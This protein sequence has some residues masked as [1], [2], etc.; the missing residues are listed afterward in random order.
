MKNIRIEYK[1]GRPALMV[2]EKQLPPVIYGLS[3]FPAAKSNT[4]Q[5]QRNIANFAAQGVRMVTADTNLSY[6]WHKFTPFDVEPIQAE[7]AG[8]LDAD[9]D[10]MVLLRLHMNPPYWWLRDHPEETAWYNGAP[11]IDDGEPVRMIRD[12]GTGFGGARGRLRVCLG[13]KLWIKEAG[14]MLKLLCEQLSK[15]PEAEHLL[16]IQVACG[17]FGEWHQWGNDDGPCMEKRF[18]EYLKE[19]YGAEISDVDSI[20]KM[21]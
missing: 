1:E 14:E 5:A 20:L 19:T 6:A 18:R 17:I 10:S 13:S 7:I 9:P 2:N 16:G 21:L 12:D 4:A 15:T 8:V 3:D 11:G